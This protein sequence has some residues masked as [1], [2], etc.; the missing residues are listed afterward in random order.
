[1][2]ANFKSQLDQFFS[3]LDDVE[4]E[5]LLGGEGI[6]EK[7]SFASDS[8]LFEEGAVSSD[9]YLI[10]KGKV[11]ISKN[12]SKDG[13]QQKVLAILGVG[14]IFGEGALLSNKT[15]SASAKAI[16]SLQV[17]VLS[18]EK[19]ERFMKEDS[20]AAVSLL[21]GLLKVLNTRLQTTNQEL[22]T[23]YD[24]AQIMSEH[25]NDMTSLVED[26]VEKLAE[27]TQTSKGLI[28]LKNTVTGEFRILTNWGGFSIPS[29][30]LVG[31]EPHVMDTRCALAIRDLQGKDLGLVVMEQE[32]L[33]TNEQMKVAEVIAEQL[34]IAIADYQFMEL[35]AGR[36]KLGQQNI[37]F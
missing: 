4:R 14:T 9:L 37:Q 26:I 3:G 24:I 35:E 30:K 22:V 16:E 27:V 33:W 28:V 1:M 21:L 7:Q 17:L 19:F 18:K 5:K 36:S 8:V 23:L 34:G 12:V 20:D 11:Q 10:L 2:S 31:L 6:W 13:A 29:E 15:R 32:G 25:K